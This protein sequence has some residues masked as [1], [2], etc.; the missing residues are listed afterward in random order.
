MDKDTLI[1]LGWIERSMADKT[2]GHGA[3]MPDLML[4]GWEATTQSL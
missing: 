4:Q 3:R 1:P 2:E